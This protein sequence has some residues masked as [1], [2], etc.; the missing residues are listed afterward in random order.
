MPGFSEARGEWVYRRLT[1]TSASTLSPGT[2]VRIAGAGTVSEFSGGQAGFLGFI[3]HDSMNSLP[4]GQC[5][6]AV[7]TPGC[8]AYCDVPTGLALSDLS[9]GAIGGI[10]KVTNH[11]S[12]FT[13]ADYSDASRTVVIQGPLDTATSRIEV[14]FLAEAGQLFSVTSNAMAA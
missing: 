10:Y 3:K 5:I 13:T 2:G 8:T 12:Y 14:S 6:V 11:C 4:T 7:P 9:L 1:I